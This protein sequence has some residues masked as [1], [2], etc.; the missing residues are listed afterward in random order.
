MYPRIALLACAASAALAAGCGQTDQEQARKATEDYIEAIAKGDYG[1][2]CRQ[3]TA[4]FLRELDGPAGCERAQADQF[5][6]PGGATATLEVANVRVN[7]ERGNVT[8]NVT[9]EGGSPSPLT[10]LM[11]KEDDEEW[12]VRGQQ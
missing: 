2:A 12:R 4:E 10:L 1:A 5:G 9:R 8:V 7:G 6:G 11:V 3:F